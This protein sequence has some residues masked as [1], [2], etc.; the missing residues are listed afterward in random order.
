MDPRKQT[1]Q[2][3]I[4]D[5]LKQ[6]GMSEFTWFEGDMF[7]LDQFV[8]RLVLEDSKFDTDEWVIINS[9][10]RLFRTIAQNEKRPV[11][12]T[13]VYSVDVEKDYKFLYRFRMM[14]V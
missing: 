3:K 14:G 1:I 4:I 11:I 5:Q 7:Y 10:F 8:S 2:E 12:S 6:R 9:F 13:F